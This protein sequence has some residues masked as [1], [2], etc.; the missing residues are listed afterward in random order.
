MGKLDNK[1]AIVTGASRGIGE[2]CSIH[3][4]KEGAK[5]IVASRN[6]SECEKVVEKIKQLGSDAIPFSVNITDFEKTKSMADFVVGKYGKV[7]ILVNNAGI[8]DDAF[9]ENMSC[10][11]W[12]NVINTNLNGTFFCTKAVVGYMIGQKYGR[13][14]N[15]A[16][17]AGQRGARTQAN[18]AASKA[19]IIGMTLTLLQELGGK[20]ITVNAVSPGLIATDMIKNIP[21]KIKEHN[22]KKIPLGRFGKVDE[23]ASVVLMLASDD[24]GYCNGM[25]CEVN[26]GMCI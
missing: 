24:G 13:I 1:V 10:G 11:Q 14:I 8:T 7:D 5:V 20:G 23:I 16:S 6:Y 4:A 3:L 2:S 25:V 22:L 9:F 26:G 18:Y 19:G 15:I 21:E 12:L 17:I